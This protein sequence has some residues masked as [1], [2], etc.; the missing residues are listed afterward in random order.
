MDGHCDCGGRRSGE[1]AGA[2]GAGAHRAWGRGEGAHHGAVCGESG[3]CDV[4]A[5]EG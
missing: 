2:G 5:A 3:V 1:A 4:L